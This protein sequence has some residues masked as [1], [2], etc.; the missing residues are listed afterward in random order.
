MRNFFL[1]L[2]AEPPL[3]RVTEQRAGTPLMGTGWIMGLTGILAVSISTSGS[4]SEQPPKNSKTLKTH[5]SD[6]FTAPFV[7]AN[8]EFIVTRL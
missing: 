5:R 7:N 4:L 8:D 1:A 2:R 3:H 6:V